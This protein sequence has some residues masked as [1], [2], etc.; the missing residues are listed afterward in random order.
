M[1]PLS[2]TNPHIYIQNPMTDYTFK[3]GVTVYHH[4]FIDNLTHFLCKN[5][6]PFKN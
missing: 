3:T 4:Y 5:V 1:I 6:R 2:S